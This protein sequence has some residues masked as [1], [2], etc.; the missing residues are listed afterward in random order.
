MFSL[1]GKCALVSGASRGIGKSVALSLAEAG[2]D[3]VL[4]GRDAGALADVRKQVEMLG[5]RAS[6]AAFDITDESAVGDATRRAIAEHGK[7]DAAVINAGVNKLKPFLEW[8]REEWEVMMNTNLVGAIHTLQAVGRH[9]T[10][11]G[12]G[13][14]ITMS[15]IYASTGAPG[16]SIYCLTK[17]GLLQLSKCVAVEWARHGVRVN[18]ICPGWI[19]TDLTAPYMTD[20]HTV[21]AGLKNIPMRRFGTPDDIGPMAVYLAADESQW[22]TGQSFVIDGGQLAR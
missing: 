10:A 11:R 15:S 14:V 4:W 20:S 13:S 18:A 19:Q 17:G 16:N 5:V 3:I 22:V 2:A 9:M 12:S 7:I 8:K 21:E 1:K 6:V